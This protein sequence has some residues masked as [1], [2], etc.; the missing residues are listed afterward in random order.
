MSDNFFELEDENGSKFHVHKK[1]FIWL[2]NN[3]QHI[4]ADRLLRFRSTNAKVNEIYRSKDPGLKK[5]DNLQKLD[6]IIINGRIAKIVDF[7]Y[8]YGMFEFNTY[9]RISSSKLL[10]KVTT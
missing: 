7:R 3:N 6:L 2:L 1:T 8:I 9:I 10:V 4:S 5:L